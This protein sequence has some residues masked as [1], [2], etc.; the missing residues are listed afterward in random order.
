MTSFLKDSNEIVYFK[1][2]HKELNEQDDLTWFNMKWIFYLINDDDW[3]IKEI[4]KEKRIWKK[5]NDI[6][7]HFICRVFYG[8]YLSSFQR[9]KKINKRMKTKETE[10]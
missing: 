8:M 5:E 1:R 3:F 4:Q 7:Q 2:I 10:H 9:K 6:K